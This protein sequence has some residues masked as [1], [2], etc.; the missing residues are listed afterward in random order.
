MIGVTGEPHYSA[1]E[2]TSG[3]T[4]CEKIDL[5]SAGVT[6]F[7]LL[8]GKLPFQKQDNE[9]IAMEMAKMGKEEELEGV[10]LVVKDLL[11]QLREVEPSLRLSASQSLEHAWFINETL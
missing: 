10:P 9:R 3:G 6:M 2:M 4:Y 11:R 1:P 5:F 7:Y 8:C